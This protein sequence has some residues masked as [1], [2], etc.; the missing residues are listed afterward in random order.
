MSRGLLLSALVL[1]L[2]CDR[3][4]VDIVRKDA[5]PEIG[6][7]MPSVLAGARMRN[8]PVD[9]P[10]PQG[11]WIV[12]AF[13]PL[14]PESERNQGRVEQLARSLPRDWALLAVAT[15]AQGVPA[16]CERLRV[17]VPVLTQVPAADLA[18][19]R[20]TSAPRTYV[21]DRN[22]ELME[23]L[24][25]PFDGEVAEKLAARFPAGPGSVKATNVAEGPPGG[26]PLPRSLCRDR[27]Q[28]LYSRGSKADAFGVRL[29]CGAEGLWV[30]AS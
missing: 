2:G 19:Y 6:T 30:P 3:L 18:A 11:G 21:L 22:W 7:R 1:A 8:A 28:G 15:E 16:F 17:T 23:V 26:K 25:G 5:E 12:Y 27:R 20:I 24:D 14:S 13:S 29:Q 10:P 4:T 9:E